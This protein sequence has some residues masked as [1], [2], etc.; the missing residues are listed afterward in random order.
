MPYVRRVGTLSIPAP[1]RTLAEYQAYIASVEN[2][3][4]APSIAADANQVAD[5]ISGFIANQSM[6]ALRAMP[7]APASISSITRNHTVSSLPGMGQFPSL[8]PVPN[9]PMVPVPTGGLTSAQCGVLPVSASMITTSQ[10]KS[11]AG[12]PLTQ[13]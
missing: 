4:Y 10:A 12:A 11:S 8:P 2:G 13:G 9:A 5:S 6:D 7:N 1:A 3:Q